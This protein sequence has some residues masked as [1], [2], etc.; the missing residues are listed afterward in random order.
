MVHDHLMYFGDRVLVCRCLPV[1]N[2][3]LG[4]FAGHLTKDGLVDKVGSVNGVARYWSFIDWSEPWLPT[5]GMPVAGLTGPITV[6][7]PALPAGAP[8]ASELAGYEDEKAMEQDY[9]AWAERL[10]AAIRGTCMTFDGMIADGPGSALVNQHGQ[11][12]GALMVTLSLEEGR[13]AR[14][15]DRLCPGTS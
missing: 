15:V 3:C 12:F 4:F 7:K 6:E 9:G 11:A 10:Q 14:W 5:Q 1:I 2:R 13:R 8:K